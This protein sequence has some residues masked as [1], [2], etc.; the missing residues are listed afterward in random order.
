MTALSKSALIV[1]VCLSWVACRQEASPPAVAQQPVAQPPT[2]TEVF[3]LR[4]KCAALGE[5]ILEGND[6]GIALTQS[7]TSH[8]DPKTNR[9]YVELTVETADTTQPL[10]ERSVFLYDGQTKE[11][12][13]F[14][15]NENGKKSGMVFVAVENQID[16]LFD[17]AII[18]IRQMM[19]DDRKQ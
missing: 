4:S 15:R 6:I 13:A 1:C 8:Y 19:A 10:N 12:L 11:V 5:Q 18:F 9:C 17:N 16:D 14:A 3:T 7:Q 2:A